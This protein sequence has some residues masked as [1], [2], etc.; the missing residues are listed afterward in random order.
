MSLSISIPERGYANVSRAAWRE[1]SADPRFWKLVDDKVLTIG[2][3]QGGGVRLVGSCYVGRAT[4]GGNTLDFV[5]KIPG[6]FAA[7]VSAISPSAVRLLK[8][9]APVSPPNT[10]TGILVKVFVGAVQEYAASKEIRYEQRKGHGSLIGGSLDVIGTIRLRS[11][12]IRHEVAFR[13]TVLTADTPL[14]RVLYAGLRRIEELRQ[15]AHCD[16]ADVV[17]ARSLSLLLD[18]CSKAVIGTPLSA[19]RTMAESLAD[20]D[21]PFE[22]AELAAAMLG[23][24]GFGGDAVAGRTVSRSWFINLENL[25]E[26]AVRHSLQAAFGKSAIVGPA[27]S[28]IR[29]FP[30]LSSRYPANTDV[31]IRLHTGDVFIADAKYKDRSHLSWPDAS[32]VQE[33]LTHASAYKAKR[34]LLIYP[35]ETAWKRR[36]GA[37]TTGCEL[38]ALGLR[39]AHLMQDATDAIREV[40]NCPS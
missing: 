26:R 12:G 10:S 3:L 1:I 7:L 18:D 24:A 27:G 22:L 14:N 20:E 9:P 2:A 16:L 39:V 15:I 4:L 11:R 32:E 36:I 38:W 29:V 6:A 28:D 31:V 19:L 37:T 17:K 40:A 33:I 23:D 13:R 21:Q 35:A 8:V 30:D 25:F 5:E 34:A